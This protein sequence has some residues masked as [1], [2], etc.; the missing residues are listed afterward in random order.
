MKV[1]VHFMPEKS[2]WDNATFEQKGMHKWAT[3]V[4]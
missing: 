1:A 4:I 2:Q 3:A